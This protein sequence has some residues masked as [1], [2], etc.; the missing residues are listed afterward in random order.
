MAW[1]PPSDAVETQASPA[2]AANTGWT[3]PS[4]AVEMGIASLVNKAPSASVVKT[5]PEPQDF[6]G[7]PMGDDFSSAI[8]AASAAPKKQSVLEGITIPELAYNPAEL[9]RLSQ[10]KYAEEQAQKF[11][12]R[13]QQKMTQGGPRKPPSAAELSG[14]MMQNANP[15]ARIGQKALQSGA[16]GFGGV[17]R[18]VGD[19]VGSDTVAGT[20][21][22]MAKNARE[23]QQAMGPA[24]TGD[25]QGFGPK[26]FVPDL[27]KYTANMGEGAASSLAQSIAASSLGPAAVIPT[28]SVMSAG[29]QYNKAREAGQST[30]DSLTNAVPYGIFEAVGEKF[31]GLDKVAGAMK[32]LVNNGASDVVKKQ[33]GDTLLKMGVREIPGEVITYLGQTGVDLLPGIGLNPNLTMAEFLNGLRD[34]V[35]QAGMMG[36]AVAGAGKY[37]Q[38]RT[39]STQQAQIPSAEQMMR[40]RGFLIPEQKAKPPIAPIAPTD[41]RIEPTFEPDKFEAAPPVVDKRQALKDALADKIRALAGPSTEETNAPTQ[42]E[43]KD[44]T[45]PISEAGG[46]SLAIPT[47]PADNIPPTGGIGETERDGVVP[48]GQDA[49]E[50]AVGEGAQPA[51][52]E[53]EAEQTQFPNRIT[54]EVPIDQLQLSEDVPQFKTDANKEG[55]VEPLGGKFERTGVAPIQVW[56]RKDGRMEII[57]GRHRFDLAKRSGEKTI[58]AQIH[59]EDAG[60]TKDMAAV[61]DAELNIRDGQGKVK[62]YVNYFKGTGLD[63]DTAESR[64]LLARSTGKRAF[65]ISNQGSDEL[66][67]SVRSDKVGDEAAYLIALNAPNDS[68]LQSVGIKAIQEGKSAAAAVNLMQAVKALAQESD[69]TTDMFGFDESAMKE[70]EEMAKIAASKQREMQTRLSAITGAAKN[71]ALA[72]AEG[73]DIRDPEAIKRRIDELRQLK[74]S[75]DN[76]STNPDL[77]AE[78]RAA[79]GTPAP[80]AQ[81]INLESPTEQD[82]A[83]QEDRKAKAE[84]LD[85]QEQIRKESEAGADQFE[86]TTEEGRQ[87]TTGNL[88]DQPAAEEVIASTPKKSIKRFTNGGVEVRYDR[89]GGYIRVSLIPRAQDP[90][91]L[92]S[93]LDSFGYPKGT[94]DGAKAYVDAFEAVIQ[95]AQGKTVFWDGFISDGPRSNAA[96]A[97]Y[98]KLKNAGIPFKK[99]EDIFDI[100]APNSD[101]LTQED[102][103]NINFNDVRKKLDE[104]YRNREA[105]QAAARGQKDIFAEAPAAEPETVAISPEQERK[106]ALEQFERQLKVPIPPFYAKSAGKTRIL[107]PLPLTAS[108]IKE[109]LGLASQALDL[110]MPAAVLGNVTAG[111]STRMG[112]AAA[113]SSQGELMI[114]SQWK[115][116]SPAEKLQTLI[117]E[118]GHSID[119]KSNFISNKANWSKAHAELKN[120]Y[121]GSANKFTHPLAYPFLP[122]FKGK[123][124]PEMESFAQAFGYYFTSPVDLQKNAPEA[125]SQIQAI[126]ERIQDGSQKARAAGTTER[127]T[128]AINVQPSRVEK[129]TTVQPNAGQVSA[130]VSGTE[131]L[132]DRDVREIN[133]IDISTGPVVNEEKKRNPSLKR[134]LDKLNRDRED[135]KIT[136]EAFIEG[137]DGALEAADNARMYAQ[138]PPRT[139]GADFIRQRLLEA[140]RRGDLSEEAVDFAEWFIQRN[141][142]L[143]DDLGVSIRASKQ[144]G[145]S[146]QYFDAGRLMVLMKKSGKDTTTVHEI[147]HHLERMMPPDMQNAIRKAWSQEFG[148]AT[149]RTTNK[150]QK[151]FFKLLGKYHW[152]GEGREADF[153]KAVQMVKDGQVPSEFYQY[154]NPSEFWAVNGTDIMEGRFDAVR[155]GVLARM[156]N[157]LKELVQ[158][159]K[160]MVGMGSTGDLIKAL[161][162]LSK[163]DGKFQSKEMLGESSTYA[164]V[165][166]PNEDQGAASVTETPKFKRWFGGS[167]V[168]D[169][170][171]KPL[172][173]YHGTG[174]NFNTFDMDYADREK[175]WSFSTSKEVAQTYKPQELSGDKIWKKLQSLEGQA[176]KRFEKQLEKYRDED[177]EISEYSA[178]DFAAAA[179][180]DEPR[181]WAA[182]LANAIDGNASDFYDKNGPG[183]IVEAYLSLKNPIERWFNGTNKVQRQSVPDGVTDGYIDYDVMDTNN[184]GSQRL[185]STVY[186]VNSSEQIISATDNNGGIETVEINAS[187]L[188]QEKEK[189][190]WIFGRDKLGRVGFGP[191]AVAYRTIADITNKVLDKLAMKPISPELGRAIRNMKAKV[192]LAKNK[193]AEVA[194]DMSNLSPEEREMISDVIEGELKAG[195]HPPQHV[196]NIAAAIQSMMS[197]QSK[198][199]VDLGMLSKEAANRWENKYLPRFYE[200]QLKDSVNAWSKAAKEVFMKQPMMRGIRGSNLRSRGLY[201]VVAVDDLPNWLSEGWEQRDPKFDPKKS[202]ETIVWRDYTREERENMG[203]IRDAMFRFVMGYNASQRDIALG[204]LYKDLAKS[205][206][207]PLPLD[208]YV[209][210]P[211]GNAEG[212]GA[213]RYGALEG[214]YVP[215]EIMDHL[216]ANDHAMAEGILKIY[217]AGLSRWKE[218]KT[219][220]NPVSHA[221]NVI[222]NVTM[223]HFAGVSY[224]D[225][226][227]YAG[228][229][230]DLAKNNNMVKEAQEVGLFGGTFSQADLIK[231]MPPELRA[232][233]NLTESALSRFGERIWD[234]LAFTVEVGGKKYG[235]R[236]AMQWAYENEDL[237][238]R[239]VIYRDA[240][241]RGMDPEDA[242]DYSQE[243]IFTYDDLPKGARLLR[244]YGMPF[245]SYTY[246]VVPVLAQTALK[247][248]WRY[249]AP[250]TIAY[251]A[252]A[253]MYAIAANLGGDDDDWWGKVLYKYITDEEFRKKAKDLEANERRNLP[254]WM[255]GHSAILSTPKAIRMGIDEATNLPMFLDISRIFPGGDL[256]DANNNS[257]GVALIQPL[258]PSNPVLTSLVAMLGNKD[259]F[260]GKDVTNKTD[261][262]EEKAVK[263]AAWLW[264]QITPAISVGNYHFD[265]A[266]NAT[267]NMTG[268]PITIDAGPLGVTSYTGVGKDGLPVQPKHAM[269]Q[270]MGIKI[271]PYD[272]EIGE[273]FDQN[274]KRALVRELDFSISRINRQEAKGVISPEAAEIE[275]QKLKEKKSN[276][277]QGLTLSGEEK[278]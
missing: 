224:W 26:S 39:P 97:I 189:S 125:Y 50:L 221:N 173:V 5:A 106:E 133:A 194:S 233:A 141:P 140:K 162:S 88:F 161:D 137:V 268:K 56:R 147:L 235:A 177:G 143:V 7:S 107:R 65:T 84:K 163:G 266:M 110:G 223:A 231:S 119:F 185:F 154:V 200:R 169:A 248:P 261:T 218:G 29:G 195:V 276:I 104:A 20:G 48:T 60:F 3:P 170:K 212:T 38:S 222:S 236:P 134:K 265:R 78:I 244:D 155:G 199:L 139:R 193:V 15:L 93:D 247:Y 81:P 17:L 92:G 219:V 254:E 1:N 243:F 83:D 13:Y 95:N 269:L 252:N 182:D 46:E 122:K 52:V 159:I 144:D 228:A 214:M 61:L 262:D 167:K 71:P 55:V 208:G 69:T 79:R 70:A 51:A 76:W 121:D 74:A 41:E 201:E 130:A 263:R 75:W 118:L 272:L 16:E 271:R 176:R 27:L 135:G 149:Q 241:N 210:V 206:A 259:L 158:K 91:M 239:Y 8:M 153:E 225:A 209:Q 181:Q 148:K 203:E 264:K 6:L 211:T 10:R 64:G 58:P 18:A 277:K 12:P 151:D 179:N 213:A 237:F 258:T 47:Q 42:E 251:T 278:K 89:D 253:M 62:D 90:Y 30:F 146:G 68:R 57:S 35:V 230:K 274:K 9:T 127:G 190:T 32:A 66:I 108:Q 178:Q 34:T 164:S 132:K 166:E 226:H 150:A 37:L 128:A 80:K 86:L 63:Q 188:P 33:A 196:L 197:R 202:V 270:T 67:A 99:A 111:G 120:W 2:P 250:A 234:T 129:D 124:Y 49:T 145:V 113:L 36:G 207:S 160:S 240:R 183:K 227:K 142:Q 217:R 114:S 94:G 275:R 249:A 44:V 205:Y 19:V 157:W 131:G 23:Y 187:I 112:G 220:L 232:M 116:A 192:E 255:K 242:R 138:R 98:E 85:E 11:D 260:L 215:K 238:F 102:L 77:I 100:A 22:Y 54:V 184:P 28:L 25:I 180:E 109:L 171:G 21:E 198:E 256:L 53:G 14:G 175:N 204:R 59:D 96:L 246:K 87:D 101:G 117:H 126:I 245:F 229:I 174:G 152:H 4:D 72:K 40:E 45:E 267:A 115:T 165:G 168:V 82:V 156:K 105:D 43:A 123:V 24:I 31:A 186:H 73:I 216:S 273:A 103:F 191:G 172:V 136:D 257:G